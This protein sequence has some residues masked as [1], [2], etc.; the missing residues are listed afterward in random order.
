MRGLAIVVCALA[1]AV[2]VLGAELVVNPG[3]ESG[4]LAPWVQWGPGWGDSGPVAVQSV[5]VYEG[6]YAAEIPLN[7]NGGS[8]GFKQLVDVPANTPL[9]FSCYVNAPNP[10]Q[11]WAEVLLFPDAVLDDTN[12]D[13]GDLSKPFMIWKRDSW[14]GVPGL[15]GGTLPTV[16]ALGDEGWEKVTGTISSSTG[17]VTIAFKWGGFVTSSMLVDGVSLTPEPASLLI[18]LAGLPLLRR[19]RR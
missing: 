15:P 6:T 1:A 12:I 19:S 7:A 10:G 3:F 5:T 18:L 13:S 8:Y 16:D 17:T 4:D 11:N 14:T 2:P 9:T